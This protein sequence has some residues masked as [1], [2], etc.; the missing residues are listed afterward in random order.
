[1]KWLQYWTHSE[2]TL[3][4]L[5]TH[6]EHTLNTP[7]THPEHTLNTP[8]THMVPRD[9]SASK[10]VL[11][12][13][14]NCK[15]SLSHQ[16]TGKC[17]GSILSKSN[18]EILKVWAKCI[19][20]ALHWDVRVAEVGGGKTKIRSNC[21]CQPAEWAG[22]RHFCPGMHILALTGQGMHNCTLNSTVYNCISLHWQ[23][24]F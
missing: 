2:H 19:S 23:V 14:T 20:Q 11:E 6:S 1:M 18:C 8:W 10:E 16:E 22:L 12:I 21:L 3:N 13:M 5:W 4:T 15:V 24:H 7:W 17:H 9:A